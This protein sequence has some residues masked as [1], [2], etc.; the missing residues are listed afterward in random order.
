M[1]MTTTTIWDKCMYFVLLLLAIAS[2]LSTGATSCAIGLGAVF[3]I[4]Q[5]ICTGRLPDMDRR[6]GMV[7]LLFSLLQFLIA[8][9][10]VNPAAS[11]AEV[12][13]ATYRFAPLFFAMM[14]IR[15]KEQLRWIFIALI[16][17][18]FIDDCMALYQFLHNELPEGFNTTHI[19]FGDFV[20]MAMPI[21]LLGIYKDYMPVWSRLLAAV[22]LVFS[23]AMLILSYARGSWIALAAMLL[24]WILFDRRMR[25]VAI[26]LTV[27]GVLAFTAG[28]CI[29][30]DFQG[31][32]VSVVN[33]EHENNT[34]RVLMWE[35]ALQI[36]RDYPVFGIGQDQFA[37]I[38]NSKYISPL[39][40]E[41]SRDDNP[42]HGLGHPHNNFLKT[43]SEG[44]AVGVL[45]FLLLYGYLLY[46]L[47]GRYREESR[48]LRL[49]PAL[50]GILVWVAL[51]AA[52]L[53]DTNITQVPIM[54]EYWFLMGTLLAAGKIELG[55][56]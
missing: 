49:S 40:R 28:M 14:Y 33:P 45:A 34:E 23:F 7:V 32:V 51:Q 19:F 30:S 18:V 48:S 31:R 4:A 54:R 17:A 53:T 25:R 41:R 27:A 2:C 3:M 37:L 29:S 10:S 24:V 55:S 13:A 6:V 15:R 38:Y 12:L 35:S 11:F 36:T 1:M 50:M 20:L 44:G 39:A 56:C 47:Y 8:A 5:R 9:L 16:L 21:L 22:T 52:G 46:A 26:G 43:S 42:A